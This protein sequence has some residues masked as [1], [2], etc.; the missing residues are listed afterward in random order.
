MKTTAEEAKS[1]NKG[2]IA[3]ERSGAGNRTLG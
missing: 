2:C 3:A 1:N